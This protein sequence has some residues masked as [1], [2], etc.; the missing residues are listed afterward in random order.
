MQLFDYGDNCLI[1][2]TL[3]SFSSVFAPESSTLLRAIQLTTSDSKERNK[4]Y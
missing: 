3:H 1:L 2:R 4:I